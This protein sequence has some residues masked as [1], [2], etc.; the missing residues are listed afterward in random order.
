MNEQR[1]QSKQIFLNWLAAMVAADARREIQAQLESGEFDIWF[2]HMIEPVATPEPAD[3]TAK[4]IF[5][6]A[7]VEMATT[8]A[9]HATGIDD[10]TPF[11]WLKHWDETGRID[12]LVNRIRGA[13]EP[14]PEPTVKPGEPIAVDPGHFVLPVAVT[15][16]QL[17]RLYGM[18]ATAGF[19]GET[20]A[21]FCNKIIATGTLAERD[22]LTDGE[23]REMIL[24]SGRKRTQL[25]AVL[26]REF[27]D[28]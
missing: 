21:A 14:T 22:D 5:M 8:D 17:A 2:D 6:N 15:V 3:A 25:T 20:F 1:E 27:A 16:A 23:R 24:L 19:D 13:A 7:L 10:R 12:R 18:F 11:E 9:L 4:Q 28:D 26:R